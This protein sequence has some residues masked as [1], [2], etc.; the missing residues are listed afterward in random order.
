LFDSIASTASGDEVP[1]IVEVI[2]ITCF[3]DD[4]V[5][6]VGF[7]STVCALVAITF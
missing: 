7:S 5:N 6:G 3:G 1:W 4:V 2:F